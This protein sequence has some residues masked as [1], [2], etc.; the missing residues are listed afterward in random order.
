MPLDLVGKVMDVHHRALHSLLCQAI[1]HMVQQ[2]LA[3][4]TH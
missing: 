2:R 4:N 3:A 1:E